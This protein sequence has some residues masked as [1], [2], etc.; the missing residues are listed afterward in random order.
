MNYIREK[1]AERNALYEARCDFVK[2]N[3]ELPP[4]TILDEDASV[5]WNREEVIRRNR[6]RK[7]KAASFMAKINQ[8]D[9]DINKKIID[10]IQS[11]YGFTVTVAEIVFGKAYEDGHSAGCE[12]VVAYACEY[13]SFTERVLEAMDLR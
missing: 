10:Y 3:P 11:E 2:Q 9:S 12:E 8:C 1:S 5:R 6:S 13:A 7:G 4:D